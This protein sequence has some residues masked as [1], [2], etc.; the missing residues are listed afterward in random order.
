MFSWSFVQPE[1]LKTLPGGS[2]VGLD[3]YWLRFLD[4]EVLLL[5]GLCNTHCFSSLSTCHSS[6]A[7]L[8]KM[9]RKQCTAM[10]ENVSRGDTRLGEALLS[11]WL[12]TTVD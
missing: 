4:G 8:D 6:L 1:T 3:W 10:Q 5:V 9:N 7:L 12:L 2:L 11:C